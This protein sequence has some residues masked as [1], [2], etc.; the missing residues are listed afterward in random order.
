MLDSLETH[1]DG[2]LYAEVT[3]ECSQ[4]KHME[5]KDVIDSGLNKGRS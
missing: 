4:E 2:V 1:S 3:G 5:C